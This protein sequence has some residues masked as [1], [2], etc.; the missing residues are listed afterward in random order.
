MAMTSQFDLLASIAL[1]PYGGKPDHH[2]NDSMIF[3]IFSA[4]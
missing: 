1:N 4:G 2:Q 3:S